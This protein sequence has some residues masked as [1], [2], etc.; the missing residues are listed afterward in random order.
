MPAHGHDPD[1]IH[2]ST[3]NCV[4]T[5]ASLEPGRPPSMVLRT[6]RLVIR[7]VEGDV[8]TEFVGHSVDITPSGRANSRRNRP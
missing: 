6:S 4:T 7:W 8:V 3:R 2:C 1:L 5:N